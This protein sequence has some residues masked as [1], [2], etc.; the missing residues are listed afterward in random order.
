MFALTAMF[1]AGCGGTQPLGSS[2]PPPEPPA[3]LAVVPSV[4]DL[5]FLTE[6]HPPFNHTLRGHPAGLSVVL[7]E[8]M[9]NAVGARTDPNITVL[10]WSEGYARA[11]AAP[12]VCLFSTARTPQRQ[13]LFTWVGPIAASRIAVVA[14]KGSGIVLN[15]PAS[16]AEHTYS[17]IADDVGQQLLLAAGVPATNLNIAQDTDT[18]IAGLI[19]G[20][21]TA[22]AFEE[23]SANYQ[24]AAARESLEDYETLYI[25]QEGTLSF[26]CHK[27]TDLALLTA[28]TDALTAVAVSGEQAR[29]VEEHLGE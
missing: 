24:I 28:L 26:A 27:D 3:Q 22:W 14:K 20:S 1:I 29:I 5:V 11:Q 18:I 21:V 19:D 16:L 7:L 2:M 6:E 4:D 9:F 13:A 15:T 10:P 8:A 23:A 25:L 12:G 17:V